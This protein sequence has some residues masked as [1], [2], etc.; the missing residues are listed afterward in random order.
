MK[1]ILKALIVSLVAVGC[2]GADTITQTLNIP[3]H[4]P[5]A[6]GAGYTLTFDQFN[7]AGATL[8]SITVILSLSIYGG[9][10]AFD[11]ESESVINGTGG[12]GAS[13]ALAS[14]DVALLNDDMIPVNAW[15]N[16]QLT[17]SQVFSLGPDDGD[18][19]GVQT[20]GADYG[21]LEGPLTAQGAIN[22]Q[23]NDNV[24]S[25][26]WYTGVGYVGAGTYN[27]LYD[28]DQIVQLLTCGPSFTGDPATAFG[29]VTVIYNYT[30]VPEPA[31]ASLAGLALLMLARRRR[32]A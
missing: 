16:A 21:S 7:V 18:G 2:A 4:I 19:A 11:N 14:P 31:T 1:S 23:I 22:L 27:I 8:N 13:A 29:S 30:P 32:R 5:P 15:G 9:N 28:T 25:A 17:V 6:A 12:F 10:I 24:S 20:T 3:A 26:F